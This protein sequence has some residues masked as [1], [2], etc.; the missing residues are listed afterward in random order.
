MRLLLILTSAPGV[1]LRAFCIMPI[2]LQS[3]NKFTCEVYF[4]T[5]KQM[6]F[7]DR[8]LLSFAKSLYNITDAEN[9]GHKSLRDVLN[10]KQVMSAS[11]WDAIIYSKEIY[12]SVT[13]LAGTSDEE[14]P[15]ARTVFFNN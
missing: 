3:Y 15:A 8:K 9:C 12:G 4:L 10:D 1:Q 6:V 14:A 2:F 7:G 5:P 11:T 13:R